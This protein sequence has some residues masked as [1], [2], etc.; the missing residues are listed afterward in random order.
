MATISI[1]IFF[2][3]LNLIFEILARKFVILKIYRKL[4]PV[5]L[6]ITLSNLVSFTFR[7][8]FILKSATLTFFLFYYSCNY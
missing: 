1:Q 4:R 2:S 8:E 7:L 6:I 5:D 3:Q